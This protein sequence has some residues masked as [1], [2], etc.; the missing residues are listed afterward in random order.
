[1]RAGAAIG[2]G[3]SGR[4]AA[5]SVPDLIAALTSDLVEVRCSAAW[6][7]GRIGPPA[8]EAVDA[9]ADAVWKD[10]RALS[11]AAIEAL[12][13]IGLKTRSVL[14]TLHWMLKIDRGER[15]AA[16][17]AALERMDVASGGR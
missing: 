17:R 11:L 3:R 15:N 10:D 7:L 13:R 4:E 1:V 12:G 9:L 5:A 6:A 8:H 16:V 14:S 2:L